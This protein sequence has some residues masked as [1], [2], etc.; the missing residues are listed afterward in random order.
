M[1]IFG[2]KIKTESKPK[3]EAAYERRKAAAR[4]RNVA[5]ATEGRDIGTIPA[6][7]NSK[8]REACARN[9]RLYCETYFPERFNLAWS[10]D[11]LEVIAKIET[12]V[13]YGGLFAE[14]MPRGD[15][16][17]SIAEVAV[18]WGGSYGYHMMISVLAA[19]KSKSVEILDSIKVELEN[20]PRLG[21]DFPEICY[22]IR[23]LDGIAN[24]CKGQL[25][26]GA[27]TNITWTK[28]KII[29][30][31]I[32]GSKASGI[33]IKVGGLTGGDIRGMK[34]TRI[35]GYVVRP[36]FVMIDDPQTDKTARSRTQNEVREKLLQGAVLGMAGPGKKIAAVMPCT[37]IQ[38]GDMADRILDRD[39]HPDWNGV[40]KKMVYAWPSNEKLWDEY[41]VIRAE[42]LRAEDGGAA[43]NEFYRKHRAAMDAGAV[44][45]WP[46]RFNDNE[47]SAIQHA[48]NLK[49]RDESTFYAEYQNEPMDEHADSELLTSDQIA[50]K[51]NGFEQYHIPI[52]CH[53]LTLYEDVHD[54][55]IYWAIVAWGEG[56]TGYV[57]AYGAYPD[58]HKRFFIMRNAQRTL[59]RAAPGAGREGAIFAGLQKLNEEILSKEYIRADGVK[60]RI[61]F[62]MIDSGWETET[63]NQFIAQHPSNILFP[64]KGVAVSAASTPWED[65]K[66]KKGEMLGN[67][68]KVAAIPGKAKGR[69][70]QIDANFWKSF[71]HARLAVAMGDP[72]C[73]SLFGRKRSDGQP[74][75]PEQH[76][77]IAEHLT[78]EFRVITMGHGRN[79]DEWKLL[80]NRPDNHLFDCLAGCA[81]GA[82]ILGLS[83]MGKAIPAAPAKNK[84]R[85]QRVSYLSA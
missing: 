30:P 41:A 8:R 64:S 11:H 50:A 22:P 69:Y 78:A 82:S 2:T 70:I 33:I 25:C 38:P 48:M 66:P 32:E 6:V 85:R 18:L 61:N 5:M 7:V 44:V 42:G 80:P 43:A 67:H 28:D 12:S 14:A 45:G 73:L 57:I 4:N 27:H 37:V 17:T 3:K 79:V 19:I 40:R 68:W 49:L 65:R 51:I 74:A 59:G 46:A 15:G 29:F 77:M 56:F 62:C 72:G 24:R 26:N 36:S 71:I 35:D 54:K 9:L 10:D 13:L 31:T 23:C 47:V 60:L 83:V 34:H 84:K 1:A 39:K 63:V 16:K 20:N 53:Y 81:V 21:D 58:Q 52:E 76:R 75:S 55:V